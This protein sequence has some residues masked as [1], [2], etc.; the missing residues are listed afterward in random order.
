[1]QPA[2]CVSQFG[3]KKPAWC[4][5]AVASHVFLPQVQ[6]QEQSDCVGPARMAPA[7]PP[8]GAARD[9][10]P[11]GPPSAPRAARRPGDRLHLVHVLPKAQV[12]AM[13]GA[14]PVDFL[15][16]Q[17]PVAYEQLL[18]NA[19]HFITDRFLPKLG[20]M[21][22]DPV[23]HI[24]KARARPAPPAPRGRAGR[25]RL[26]GS[27]SRAPHMCTALLKHVGNRQTSSSCL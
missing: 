2:L 8:R 7:G 13:F 16:R 10:A 1:V 17:D 15:P 25:A 27:R 19:E 12:A 23:V 20:S 24:V 18:Q 9:P 6:A 26:V 22:P 21:Q 3:V 11:A 4:V 5:G 14:P